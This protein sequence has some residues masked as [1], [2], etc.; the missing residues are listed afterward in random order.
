M[1]GTIKRIVKEKGFGFIAPEKGG[2]YFFHRTDFNGFWEKFK[3]VS[4]VLFGGG[5]QGL[6]SPRSIALPKRGAI[7]SGATRRPM[8][9]SPFQCCGGA[10]RWR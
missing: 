4:Q 1:T 2:E 8:A 9:M 7:I 10:G 5:G 3:M 6:Q